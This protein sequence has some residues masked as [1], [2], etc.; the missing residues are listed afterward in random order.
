MEILNTKLF[1]IGDRV[2]SSQGTEEGA[3]IAYTLRDKMFVE[4][5]MYKVKWDTRVFGKA[6]WQVQSVISKIEI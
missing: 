4:R 3:I 6:E 1:K 5:H 2:V